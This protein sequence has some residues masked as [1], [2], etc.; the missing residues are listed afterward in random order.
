MSQKP[1]STFIASIHK[2]LPP[3][4]YRMKNHNAYNGGIPDVWYSG[5]DADLWVEYK[6][7][8][9]P[10]QDSTVVKIDLSELQKAWLKGRHY[11]GRRVA[12]IVGHA[13][14]GVWLPELDWDRTFTKRSFV[15]LSDT[16]QTLA[17]HIM[18][19]TGGPP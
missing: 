5:I 1:E 13:A 14:G 17:G 7:I 18:A 19:V 11:E 15:E 2:L 10:K 8:V 12:V 16:R 9:E 3:K 6:F 4:L